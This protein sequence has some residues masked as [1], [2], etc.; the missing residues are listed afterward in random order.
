MFDYFSLS[1]NNP[2]FAKHINFNESLNQ[3]LATHNCK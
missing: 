3:S 1:K 2:Y